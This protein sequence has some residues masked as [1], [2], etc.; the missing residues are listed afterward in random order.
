MALCPTIY[1][2]SPHKQIK[3]VSPMNNL[4]HKSINF[5]TLL[6]ILSVVLG[7][8]WIPTAEAKLGIE[9]CTAQGVKTIFLP[10]NITTENKN[11][12]RN[13]DK[14]TLNHCLICLQSQQFGAALSPQT[15][16]LQPRIISKPITYSAPVTTLH[17]ASLILTLAPRAPPA[18]LF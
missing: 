18:F 9:I 8:L 1:Y 14:S 6:S 2:R 12:P 15:L 7:A 17:N 5:I 4:R 3:T 10:A 11:P 13:T 16:G